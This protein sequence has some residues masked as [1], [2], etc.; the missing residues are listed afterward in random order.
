M[1]A[2]TRRRC[3]A[4]C[5]LPAE[6]T[7]NIVQLQRHPAGSAPKVAGT[8]GASHLELA[9]AGVLSR[10]QQCPPMAKIPKTLRITGVSRGSPLLSSGT[11]NPMFQAAGF[12]S[13]RCITAAAGSI[14]TRQNAAD[15]AARPQV[16]AGTAGP[17]ATASTQVAS[18]LAQPVLKPRPLSAPQRAIR[19]PCRRRRNLTPPPHR[20]PGD[21]K[22]PPGRRPRRRSP[23]VTH[24]SRTRRT[25]SADEGAGQPQSE[26]R[27][28]HAAAR[29]VNA[30]LVSR[31]AGP[32]ADSAAG[33][34]ATRA[35]A[36]HSSR[37]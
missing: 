12:F 6:S 8:L 22:Q 17:P 11:G 1:T 20:S 21:R 3:G 33:G 31:P 24:Q 30:G 13:P 26:L 15:P 28:R 23:R 37:S 29:R 14:A 36:C 16:T 18:R 5:D 9:A 10:G 27:S 4:T 19:P 7:A 34:S 2:T 32:V 35:A 25:H